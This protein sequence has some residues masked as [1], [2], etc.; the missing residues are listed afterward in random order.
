M[1]QFVLLTFFLALISFI[2]MLVIYDKHNKQKDKIE[3]EINT[4]KKFRVLQQEL[5]EKIINHAN[6]SVEI[7]NKNG[8][9]NKINFDKVTKSF[10]L[11]DTKLDI[12]EQG[13]ADALESLAL[14]EK[15]LGIKNHE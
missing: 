9:I 10:L 6:S 11:V 1:E 13:L 8:K 5:N 7:H 4:L 15:E 3:E 14:I 12:Y 2:G